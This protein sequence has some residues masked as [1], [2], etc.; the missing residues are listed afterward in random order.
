M[1]SSRFASNT[2]VSITAPPEIL[3]QRLAALLPQMAAQPRDDFVKVFRGL[4]E[5]KALAVV[6]G[7][8]Q[9]W[10]IAGYDSGTD[11]ATKALEGC[12]I[13]NGTPCTLVMVDDNVVPAPAG[14]AE[15]TRDMARVRYRGDAEDSDNHAE[16]RTRPR[17][18]R[19]PWEADSWEYDV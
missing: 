16:H 3:G 5:H 6:P 15:T 4:K 9:W 10:R 18:S 14:G 13:N 11:V 2:V 7:T 19:S 8:T 12:Q 1:R 17:S